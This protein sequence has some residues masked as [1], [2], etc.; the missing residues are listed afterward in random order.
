MFAAVDHAHFFVSSDLL[1]SHIILGPKGSKALMQRMIRVENAWRLG[2]VVAI[3]S[4]ASQGR[5]LGSRMRKR[6]QARVA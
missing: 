1:G 2:L 5:R 6:A 3:V 4:S